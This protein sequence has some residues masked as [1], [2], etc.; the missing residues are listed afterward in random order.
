M[1]QTSNGIGRHERSAITEAESAALAAFIRQTIYSQPWARE[2]VAGMCSAYGEATGHTIGVAR[3]RAAID[4]VLREDAD[5]E[6]ARSNATIESKRAEHRRRRELIFSRAL[7]SNKLSDANT[8]ADR[9]MVIDG[10]SPDV[11]RVDRS[12]GSMGDDEL[13]VAME[14]LLTPAMLEFIANVVTVD[15]MVVLARSLPEEQFEQFITALG[16]GRGAA[17]G[18]ALGHCHAGTRAP[19]SLPGVKDL[20]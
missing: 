14:K 1:P 16:V 18:T 19:K 9:M 20:V 4:V 3:M 7:E 12:V 2:N 17:R 15:R 11:V 5:N 8:A 10:I 6:L 13:R